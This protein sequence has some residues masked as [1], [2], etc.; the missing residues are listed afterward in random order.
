MFIKIPFESE[1]DFKS[2]IREITKMSLEHDYNVNDGVVLGNFYISGE[3]KSH[4]LSVNT[5]E[6][7]YTLPFTVELRSDIDRESVDFNI[8]DFSYDIVNKT[9]LKVNIEY[10]L[11]AEINSVKEEDNNRDLF[12]INIEYSLAGDI[13]EENNP[14]DELFERVSDEEMNS[15]LEYMDDAIAIDSTLVE[16]ESEDKNVQEDKDT[17]KKDERE[18][19]EI[20]K[21]EEVK[22]EV[23]E[24][25]EKEDITDE[26]IKDRLDSENEKTI[27]D[28]IKN[29]DDTF[30]TYHVYI[31]KENDTFESISSMYKIPVSLIN[32]Y[33]DLETLNVGDKVLIPLYD[34]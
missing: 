5:E 22:E 30:V 15:D 29:E 26:I 4:E 1:I 6:F 9:S 8:E 28:T 27:M 13:L 2:N 20:I 7:K 19:E 32:E 17:I 25:L 16:N 21:E 14:D 3:Y 10:S 24:P 31:V 11:T 34:E 18:E 23:K 33:N 12:K